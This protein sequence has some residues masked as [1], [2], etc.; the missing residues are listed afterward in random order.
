MIKDFSTFKHDFDF[1]SFINE[2][3]VYLSPKLRDTLS[4]IDSPISQKL[5]DLQGVDIK[6]DIS[7]IDLSDVEGMFTFKTM[8]NYKKN[9]EE[10][11]EI[12]KK[13]GAERVMIG[14]NGVYTI[15]DIEQVGEDFEKT[16]ELV[17]G[18]FDDQH[19]TITVGRN[20]FKIGRFINAVFPGEFSQREI[21]DFT[22]SYK[23]IQKAT[24][25]EMVEGEEIRKWYLEDNY[26]NMTQPLGTSCMRYAK[27]QPYFDIYAKNSDVCKMAC[28]FELD[29]KGNKKLAGRAI[30][31]KISKVKYLRDS[32]PEFEWFMDRQYGVSDDVITKLRNY[33]VKKGWAYKTKNSTNEYYDVSFGSNNFKCNLEVQLGNFNYSRF[34]YM[35]TFKRYEPDNNVLYNDKDSDEEGYYIL[36]STGG[37]YTPTRNEDDEYSDEN[38]GTVWSDFY[39]EYIDEDYAVWSDSYDSYLHIDQAVEV[40]LGP[41]SRRGWYPDTSDEIALDG[42][43]EEYF[44]VDDMVYSETYEYYIYEGESIFVISKIT[45]EGKVEET[46]YLHEDDDRYVKCENLKHLSWFKYLSSKDKEWNICTA[47][48]KD[49]LFKDGLGEWCPVDY[50]VSVYHIKGIDDLILSEVDMEILGLEDWSRYSEIDKVSYYKFLMDSGY[51][52]KLI[53]TLKDKISKQFSDEIFDGDKSDYS[54][55]E[56]RLK[57]LEEAKKGNYL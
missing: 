30:V 46:D 39:G 40:R 18:L 24:E 42:W 20:P 8:K 22:N 10:T 29:E 28:L 21:E 6:D 47:I 37:G 57:E 51:L 3:M 32:G 16:K 43:T 2:S 34:P 31:W 26:I 15:S 27:C 36:D 50:T 13:W 4:K 35:D 55:W 41:R 45:S 33:A 44:H 14:Q 5:L 56:E 53:E 19:S 54:G 48:L 9:R 7:F 52:D 1:S 23:A 49:I 12:I 25:V 11:L 38:D 17:D